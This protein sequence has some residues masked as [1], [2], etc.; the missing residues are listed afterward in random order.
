MHNFLKKVGWFLLPLLLFC[1]I[2]EILL[3]N[4]PN[5]YSV[6]KNYLNKNAQNIEVLILG[7]SHF[8]RGLNPEYFS[9]KSYNAGY[10]SQSL[11][12]DA[13]IY[14]KYMD[15][16][17]NLKYLVLNISNVSLFYELKHSPESWRTKNYNLYYDLPLSDIL[18]QHTELFS[19]K[20]DIS[21]KR[22]MGYYIFGKSEITT[23]TNGWGIFPALHDKRGVKEA[24]KKTLARRNSNAKANP[25]YNNYNEVVKHVNEMVASAKEKGIKVIFLTSPLSQYYR[26]DVDTSMAN[27]TNSFMKSLVLKNNN[28][29]YV[30]FSHDDSFSDDD[31]YDGDHLN[32]NG[33]KKFSIKADSVI[34]QIEKPNQILQKR[35]TFN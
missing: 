33:A 24:A 14:K 23:S 12:I 34:M 21:L 5:D 15:S 35:Q 7:N 8:Y 10:V 3:R 13:Q 32:K 28:C 26:D 11:D 19:L 20:F 22:I 1:V 25:D 4:I 6:K 30:D 18:A 16:F 17:T 31:F 27:Q 2:M 29:I 9:L